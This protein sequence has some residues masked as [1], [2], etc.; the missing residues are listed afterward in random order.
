MS[1]ESCALSSSSPE[2]PMETVRINPEQPVADHQQAMALAR[3]AAGERFE[4]HMLISW[5][6][7]DRDLE[8]P[9]NTTECAGDCPKDGY[10]HYARSHGAKLKIDI[11]DGRF[12]FF[13]TPLEW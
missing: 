8:S 9:A 7:R 11:E 1:K 6:D 3:E 5:Y 12:V 2:E 13:F 4:D 10:I